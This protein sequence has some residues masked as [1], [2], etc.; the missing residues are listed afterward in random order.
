MWMPVTVVP[1]AITQGVLWTLNNAE[2]RTHPVFILCPLFSCAPQLKVLQQC[3][4]ASGFR[5]SFPPRWY[6]KKLQPPDPNQ[7]RRIFSLSVRWSYS[8]KTISIRKIWK[9]TSKGE[10]KNRIFSCFLALDI[11]SKLMYILN[12]GSIVSLQGINTSLLIWFLLWHLSF[13]WLCNFY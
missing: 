8:W 11:S 1:A 7:Q 9:H 5:E 12:L 6:K 4:V 3:M 10:G 2:W 13:T